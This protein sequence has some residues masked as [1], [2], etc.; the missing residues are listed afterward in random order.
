MPTG[1]ELTPQ[2]LALKKEGEKLLKVITQQTQSKAVLGPDGMPVEQQPV[3]PGIT[4]QKDPEAEKKAVEDINKRIAEQAGKAVERKRQEI[5]E[6]TV[7]LKEI[8][9]SNSHVSACMEA[10]LVAHRIIAWCK[11]EMEFCDERVGGKETYYA[12]TIMQRKAYNDP[13]DITKLSFDTRANVV[14]LI[15]LKKKEYMARSFSR[16]NKLKKLLKR[17]GKAGISFPCES[18]R[19]PFKKGGLLAGVV[20]VHGE[21]EAVLKTLSLCSAAHQEKDGGKVT[22]LAVDAR[23][24]SE[25]EIVMPLPWWKGCA[26]NFCRMNKT[27]AT[28]VNSPTLL[29]VAEDLLSFG[30]DDLALPE[31]QRRPYL[32]SALSQWAVENCVAVIVGDVGGPLD[33]DETFYGG[34]PHWPAS[35]QVQG[36]KKYLLIGKDPFPIPEEKK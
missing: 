24:A 8:M 31:L 13:F 29:V 5:E 1:D 12:E 10:M 30:G 22:Y 9:A 14:G 17:M 2:E 33:V 19:K 7:R 3:P 34:L 18:M 28:V 32:L 4:V 20:V 36:D 15:E 21:K 16:R 26:S 11:T 23:K 35:I 6:I 25:F 27:L